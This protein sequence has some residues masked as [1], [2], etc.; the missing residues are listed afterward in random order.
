LGLSDEQITWLIKK[1]DTDQK[2]QDVIRKL[3]DE[4]MMEDKEN[5]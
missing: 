3:I 2:V 1:K 4:K 5:V